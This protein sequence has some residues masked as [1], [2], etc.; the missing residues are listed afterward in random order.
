MLTGCTKVWTLGVPSI[1]QGASADLGDYA[2]LSWCH[3]GPWWRKFPELRGSRGFA[4]QGTPAS[5]KSLVHSARSSVAFPHS[6]SLVFFMWSGCVLFLVFESD[7]SQHTTPDK[8]DQSKGQLSSAS[9]HTPL[10]CPRVRNTAR[11]QA[12]PCQIIHQVLLGCK[13][14]SQ[15]SS[16]RCGI[17]SHNKACSLKRASTRLCA[18]VSTIQLGLRTRLHTIS[19]PTGPNAKHAWEFFAW[20]AHLHRLKHKGPKEP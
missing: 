3:S 7:C 18:Q 12:Q 11:V 14:Q 10:I 5:M 17:D 2:D 16:A 20:P 13:S 8:E 15:R 19:M 1:Y 6:L 4:S 9:D